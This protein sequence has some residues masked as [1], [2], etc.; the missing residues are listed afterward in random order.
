[1]AW[2]PTAIATD[3]NGDLRVVNVKG[4]G[5]T[6]NDRGTHNSRQWEGSVWR[7]PAPRESQLKPE[8]R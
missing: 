6:K 7:I 4:V 1:M 5:N 8:I 3:R 2:Y